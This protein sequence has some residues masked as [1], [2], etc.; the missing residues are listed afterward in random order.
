MISEI[1]MWRI[2]TQVKAFSIKIHSRYKSTVLFGNISESDLKILRN[3]YLH[4]SVKANQIGLDARPNDNAPKKEGHWL[5]NTAK[6]TYKM[7]KTFFKILFFLILFSE[8]KLSENE[9]R[10]ITRISGRNQ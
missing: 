5:H 1:N 4:W 7:A 6:E 10:T 3:K 8:Y 9:R 2:I